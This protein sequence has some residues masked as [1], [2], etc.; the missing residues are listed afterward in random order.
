MHLPK[1]VLRR[2][3]AEGEGLGLATTRPRRAREA[4]RWWT[5]KH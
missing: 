3:T 2:E 1:T 5:Q 4:V